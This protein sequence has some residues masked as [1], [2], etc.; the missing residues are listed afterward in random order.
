M[1]WRNDAERRM[2]RHNTDINAVRRENRELRRELDALYSFLGIERRIVEREG[3]CHVS[4]EFHHPSS[5]AIERYYLDSVWRKINSIVE[6][7][8]NAGVVKSSWEFYGY[9]STGGFD[10]RKVAEQLDAIAEHLGLEF[11]E[12]KQHTTV[13]PK[14]SQKAHEEIVV[15]LSLNTEEFEEQ[16]KKAEKAIEQFNQK[17]GEE[18]A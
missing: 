2:D 7:L 16:L 3:S 1:R 8:K 5:I 12:V 4:Y 6:A 9:G 11:F 13:I 14:G 17:T 10:Y 15:S 18:D